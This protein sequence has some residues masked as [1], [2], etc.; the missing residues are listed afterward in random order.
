MHLLSLC[1]RGR[2]GFALTPEGEQLYAAGFV[3]AL[4]EG[5]AKAGAPHTALATLAEAMGR[6]EASGERHWEAEILRLR[7][8]VALELGDSA[9]G[10]QSLQNAIAVARRQEGRSWELRATVSL[11]RL[12]QRQGRIDEARQTL[13]R[14]YGWF[15]E[16]FDTP[17]LMEAR[18]LLTQLSR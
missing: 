18:E 11:C 5:Q 17:D 4:A 13:E 16:G 15:T 9:A 3:R 6:V 10:G 2:A 1:R 12:W 7:G 14:I 8:E